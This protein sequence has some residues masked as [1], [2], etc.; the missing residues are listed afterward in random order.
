M[1]VNVLPYET[2]DLSGRS[3]GRE[4]IMRYMKKRALYQLLGKGELH[5]AVLRKMIEEGITAEQ[6][7]QEILFR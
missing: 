4:K 3:V 7:E 5:K 2:A 1:N 6:A